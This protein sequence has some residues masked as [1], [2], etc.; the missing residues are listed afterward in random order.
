MTQL[1]ARAGAVLHNIARI[2]S[3]YMK[4]VDF[5]FALDMRYNLVLGS[6]RRLREVRKESDKLG[7]CPNP[8]THAGR[9][10]QGNNPSKGGRCLINCIRDA[11]IRLHNVAVAVLSKRI[12][13]RGLAAEPRERQHGPERRAVWENV[14]LPTTHPTL[15]VATKKNNHDAASS[16]SWSG[17]S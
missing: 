17:T 15:P 5:K 16:S 14:G 2:K 13:G 9:N 6:Y 12:Q 10:Q 11:K 4:N 3:T 7:S 8:A 1:A